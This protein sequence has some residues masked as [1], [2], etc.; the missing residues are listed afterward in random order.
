MDF[1]EDIYSARILEVVAA[2]PE[3]D[4]LACFDG[5]AVRHSELCG[6]RVEVTVRLDEAGLVAGYGHK[7]EACLL[8]QSSASVMAQQVVGLG[9]EEIAAGC[10]HLS[11][12]LKEGGPA[13][14]GLWQDLAVLE[15]VKD[16]KPRHASMLLVF[17]ATLAAIDEGLLSKR[18]ADCADQLEAE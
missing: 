5:R 2:M 7:I 4:L 6:S 9:R 17:D 16:F 12:M 14:E 8:G 18:D 1:P 10:A 3:M 11:A 15:P 13:P